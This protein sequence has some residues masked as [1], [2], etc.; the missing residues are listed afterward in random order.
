M[1][2][3]A[4]VKNKIVPNDIEWTG[5]ASVHVRSFSCTK[6]SLSV[7]GSKKT[8]ADLSPQADASVIG[9]S[10][11]CVHAANNKRLYRISEWT[12]TWVITVQ[13]IQ[14]V[15]KCCVCRHSYITQSTMRSAF[16]RQS[17]IS[18]IVMWQSSFSGG[19]GWRC[20]GIL[21]TVADFN[22]ASACCD[23]CWQALN[24]EATC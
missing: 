6:Y 18:D 20:V 14:W 1:C 16:I 2:L 9:R 11:V 7:R 17:F 23:C 5:S 10:L 21:N 22:V 19:Q 12:I 3:L 13:P 24:C 4:V 8:A 15:V